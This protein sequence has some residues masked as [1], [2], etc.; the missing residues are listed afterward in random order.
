[1]KYWKPYI[2]VVAYKLKVI[3][4]VDYFLFLFG[5]RLPAH[6]SDPIGCGGAWNSCLKI[7]VDGFPSHVRRSPNHEFCHQSTDLFPLNFQSIIA[8]RI[9]FRSLLM[10]CL[11]YWCFLPL[12]V[13]RSSL[14]DNEKTSRTS[15]TRLRTG[16]FNFL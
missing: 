3:H 12:I 14:W 13:R 16:Q 10:I 1:M 2:F 7:S 11:R 5:H 15:T 8:Q 9:P 6:V 4:Y